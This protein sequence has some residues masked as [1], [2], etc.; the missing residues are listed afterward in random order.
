MGPWPGK[1]GSMSFFHFLKKNSKFYTGG[2]MGFVDVHDVVTIMQRLMNENKMNERYLIN[3]ENI[4]FKNLFTLINQSM[5]LN[6]PKTKMS[7]PILK[8]FRIINNLAGMSKITSTMIDHSTGTF[9]Y[10]NKKV[11]KDLDYKFIPVA[12][13]IKEMGNYMLNDTKQ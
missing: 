7:K 10:S 6:P 12:Q 9:I 3:A 2:T 8:V 13:S 5:G 1:R 11:C 4:S